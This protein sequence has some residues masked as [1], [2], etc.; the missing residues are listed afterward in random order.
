MDRYKDRNYDQD[1]RNQQRYQEKGEFRDYGIPLRDSQSRWNSHRDEQ[2][3]DTEMVQAYGIIMEY[4][5]VSKS[6]AL[7]AQDQ[8]LTGVRINLSRV[9]LRPPGR[10]GEMILSA[11]KEDLE[12]QLERI[13]DEVIRDIKSLVR[14]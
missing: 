1:Y 4:G 6:A 11:F 13:L 7:P 2:R 12:H 10:D 8:P 3:G 14:P 5:Y 9:Q